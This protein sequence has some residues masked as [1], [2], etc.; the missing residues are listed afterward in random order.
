M[1]I[2][3]VQVSKTTL[4]L[5]YLL[6]K[7]LTR[8]SMYSSTFNLRNRDKRPLLEKSLPGLAQTSVKNGAQLIS[9]VA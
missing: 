2:I 8:L 1:Y 6:T 9:G 4:I 3:S 7:A 5:A